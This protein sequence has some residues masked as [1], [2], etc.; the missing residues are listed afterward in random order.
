MHF[1]R[2][3]YGKIIYRPPSFRERKDQPNHLYRYFFEKARNMEETVEMR[4]KVFKYPG[5]VKILLHK[6]R[7]YS[8]LY[9]ERVDFRCSTYSYED[10]SI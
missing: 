5:R 7:T 1:L 10:E 6:A 4:R 2:P 3:E 9:F 8:T